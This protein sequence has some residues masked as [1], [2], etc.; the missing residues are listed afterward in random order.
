M[1]ALWIVSATRM[2]ESEF[3]RHSYLGRSLGA[4]PAALKPER[5]LITYENTGASAQGLPVV[6]NRAIQAAPADTILAFA[7][8]DVYLHDALFTEHVRVGLERFGVL[9]L[10]GSWGTPT[11]DPAWGFA[12]AQDGL[13]PTGWIERGST[14]DL[15]GAVSH[16][17][18]PTGVPPVSL[19]VY[20]DTGRPATKLDGLLLV[21]RAGALRDAK[22]LF[23][24]Q[25]SWHLYDLD[26]CA[27]AVRAGLLLG[28]WPLLVTHQSG[29]AYGTP[30]WRKAARLYRDKWT[31]GKAEPP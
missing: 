14:Q 19:S 13:T 7:H 29:G 9:G 15:T 17:I 4:W 24:A 28:T 2:S 12:F 18:A 23:D 21:S 22:V 1:T 3:W 6:Y 5:C 25:F 26:F 31:P 30:E 8:D 27:Q 16:S 20:G 11:Q 10:A